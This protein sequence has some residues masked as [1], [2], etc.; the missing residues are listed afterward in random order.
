MWSNSFEILTSDAMQH[1]ASS[2]RHFLFY[3]YKPEIE[4]KNDFLVHFERFLVY[5]FL[6]PTSYIPIF[7]QIK[8]LIEVHNCGKIH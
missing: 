1:N 2:M 3:S 6:C 4:P 5:H 7:S 8:H